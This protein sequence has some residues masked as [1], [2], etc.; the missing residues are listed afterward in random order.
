[1]DNQA[2]AIP[3]TTLSSEGPHWDESVCKIRKKNVVDTYGNMFLGKRM[4]R[5][6]GGTYILKTQCDN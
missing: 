1:M 4:E 5:P 2:S 6:K 3:E